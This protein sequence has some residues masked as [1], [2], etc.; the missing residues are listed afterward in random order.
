MKNK[1]GWKFDLCPV[2][3]N[4]F[5]YMYTYGILKSVHLY[6]KSKN[7]FK[8]ENLKLGLTWDF[9]VLC[10]DSQRPLIFSE[11]KR[12]IEPT[13]HMRPQSQQIGPIVI[14]RAFNL[15]RVQYKC[16]VCITSPSGCRASLF[17]PSAR[18]ALDTRQWLQNAVPVTLWSINIEN[19][20]NARFNCNAITSGALCDFLRPN[21]K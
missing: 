18:W 6:I 11:W 15:F 19:N 20:C 4:I 7:Q 9:L 3:S 1:I 16:F 5:I 12:E 21:G 2:K 17:K 10:T 13:R 8:N 14:D